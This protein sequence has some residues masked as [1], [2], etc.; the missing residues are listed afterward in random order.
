MTKILLVI[1]QRIYSGQHCAL[2]QTLLLMSLAL[3]SGPRS[4]TKHQSAA[5]YTRCQ[6]HPDPPGLVY[7]RFTAALT[8]S[9]WLLADQIAWRSAGAD[10]SSNG[11]D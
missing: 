4:V 1:T 2:I 7:L 8:L 11:D 3:P 9:C 10:S 5:G 6:T